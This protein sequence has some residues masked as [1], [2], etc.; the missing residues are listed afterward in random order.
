M[1]TLEER[2]EITLARS[3]GGAWARSLAGSAGA[4][5]WSAVSCAATPPSAAI[6]PTPPTSTPGAAMHAPNNDMWTTAP[7]FVS[8][9]WATWAGDATTPERTRAG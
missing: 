2:E 1:L 4:T 9:C 7:S 8:G 5:Q 6:G 3:R